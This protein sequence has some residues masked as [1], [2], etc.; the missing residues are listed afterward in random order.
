MPSDPSARAARAYAVSDVHGH[1]AELI[2]AL[3]RVGLVDGDGSWA[4]ADTRLWFLGDYVDRGSDGI[5]VVDLVMRLQHE[6]ASTGGHVGALLGNHEVLAL[7]MHEFGDQQVRSPDGRTF[8]FAESWLVNGGRVQ[9]QEGLTEAH[10]QWLRA[11]PATAREGDQLLM[12]SDTLAYLDWGA[13]I[14]AINGQLST[15]LHSDDLVSTWHCWEQMTSRFA[16]RGHDGPAAAANVLGALGGKQ[17]VHGHSPVSILTELPATE[18]TE[19][20]LYA[21]GLA[22]AIDGGL[23]SGGPCL[24]VPLP[25]SA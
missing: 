2:A 14:D 18:V 8:S 1:P 17:I 11:L 4:G 7:G 16:F 20:L 23:F 19:P 13:T 15:I 25:L 21:D 6:S 24:V 3:H 9:D 10:L 22:L 12:H 5:G